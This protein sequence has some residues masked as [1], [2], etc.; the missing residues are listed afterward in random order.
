MEG[1]GGEMTNVR[2][3]CGKRITNC[4]PSRFFCEIKSYSKGKPKTQVGL[5]FQIFL[6][7]FRNSPIP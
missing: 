2:A 6:F 5:P 1:G 3:E 7:V 4:Q